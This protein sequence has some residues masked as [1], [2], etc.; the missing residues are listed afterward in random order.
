MVGQAQAQAGRCTALPIEEFDFE[1]FECYERRDGALVGEA[2]LY[3]TSFV[4]I[5]R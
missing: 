2:L 5:M 1:L 4:S 3:L